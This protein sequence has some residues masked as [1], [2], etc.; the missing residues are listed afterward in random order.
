MKLHVPVLKTSKEP[1]LPKEPKPLTPYQQACRDVIDR[2]RD[3]VSVWIELIQLGQ[4]PSDPN[5]IEGKLIAAM[6]VFDEREKYHQAALSA[7]NTKK[8]K[9]AKSRARKRL[10]RIKAREAKQ[11]KNL[12]KGRRKN[13]Q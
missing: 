1:K 13:A 4:Y 2:A 10:A 8:E 9:A 7:W 6:M 11:G 5:T 12:L 3:C